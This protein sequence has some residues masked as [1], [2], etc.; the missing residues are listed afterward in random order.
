MR[1]RKEI[2]QE[3]QYYEKIKKDYKCVLLA[4]NGQPNV[5]EQTI[6]RLYRNIDRI[7]AKIETLEWV[8]KIIP[9]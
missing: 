4:V 8:L 1:K 2:E 7:E 6:D 9:F 5:S 3:L